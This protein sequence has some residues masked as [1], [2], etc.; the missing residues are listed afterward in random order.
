MH[1]RLNNGT[2]H[3]SCKVHPMWQS[4]KSSATRHVSSVG[5]VRGCNCTAG[6]DQLPHCRQP[7]RSLHSQKRSSA[8]AMMSMHTVCAGVTAVLHGVV[9][10]V[11]VQI[12]GATAGQ[13][14]PSLHQ[15]RCVWSAG[16]V[17]ASCCRAAAAYQPPN[18]THQPSASRAGQAEAGL[19]AKHTIGAELSCC[20]TWGLMRRCCCGRSVA[21]HS[22]L[23]L[24]SNTCRVSA[25]LMRIRLVRQTFS[26]WRCAA[27]T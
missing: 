23:M 25:T 5:Q 21:T 15:L 10:D 22:S 12:A 14:L 2:A 26:L 11:V 13:V 19:Q 17:Y 20:S 16:S 18:S 1:R 3:G 7:S 4:S 6:A 8:T 24:A 27:G 9:A